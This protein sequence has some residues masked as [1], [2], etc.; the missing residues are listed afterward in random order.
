M[1]SLGGTAGGDPSPRDCRTGPMHNHQSGDSS[2]HTGLGSPHGAGG[3]MDCGGHS[4]RLGTALERSL[5]LRFR[6]TAN[7]FP[8]S[9]SCC[10]PAVIAHTWSHLSISPSPSC[11]LRA[12]P[13][14]SSSLLPAAALGPARCVVPAQGPAPVRCL[15]QQGPRG[16][17]LGLAPV[18]PAGSG[19]RS[20]ACQLLGCWC[21]GV[22]G[23]KGFSR[24]PLQDCGE[25]LLPLV[26][27]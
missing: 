1:S 14:Q 26:W 24:P 12:H 8:G 3:C 15:G 10:S 22:L 21:N 2:H 6:L 17:L 18:L 19:W 11:Y 27:C 9:R 7:Q 16:A 4:V 23:G 13:G 5:P 25:Q 20:K